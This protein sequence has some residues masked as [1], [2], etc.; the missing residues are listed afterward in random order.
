MNVVLLSFADSHM[1]ATLQR[2]GHEAEASGFFSEVRLRTE[3]DFDEDYWNRNKDWY[4]HN[5]RGFGYWLWKPYLIYKELR[6]LSNNDILVYLDAGCSINKQ[7]EVRFKEYVSLAQN[8][9]LG[10]VAFSIPGLISQ[11]C[12]GDLLDY[13]GFYDNTEILKKSMCMCGLLIIRKCQQS[14]DFINRWFLISHEHR[15]LVDDSVS[16]KP[17]SPNFVENRHDQSLFALLAKKHVGVVLLEEREVQAFPYDGKWPPK[18]RDWRRLKHFPFWAT[19]NKT[20]ISYKA[21]AQNHNTL[22]WDIENL[23]QE[24]VICVRIKIG[25]MLRNMHNR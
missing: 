3:H 4:C 19:R 2:I 5:K 20:G 8:A 14:L 15:Y 1:S 12:K 6:S 7:G 17:D 25:G 23:I 9:D 11:Y 18:E 10:I 21:L 24:W 16:C 22:I 13:F